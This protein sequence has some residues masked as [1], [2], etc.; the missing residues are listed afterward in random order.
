MHSPP[1]NMCQG[2]FAYIEDISGKLSE[3]EAE[4]H[5]K[6][7]VIKLNRTR[8]EE[9]TRQIQELQIEKVRVGSPRLHSWKEELTAVCR[10]DMPL[11]LL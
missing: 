2:L 3:A 8:I 10:I 7:D 9:A 11:R 5:D 6:K 4:L 1:A